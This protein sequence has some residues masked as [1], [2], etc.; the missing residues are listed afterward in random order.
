[1]KKITLS[2]IATGI[3]LAS[4]I[5][6][7]NGYS[8]FIIGAENFQYSE[9][10]IYTF[11]NAYIVGDKTYLPGQSVAVK[12][13]INVTSPVYMSGG[14]VRFSPKWDLS[15]DFI[16]TLKPNQTTEKW[17]DRGEGNTIITNYATIMSNSMRFLLHYKLTNQHRIAFGFNYILNNFKRYNNPDVQTTELVEETSASAM[18]D[19][20]YWFESNTAGKGFRLKYSIVG[21][22]P[23]Y[24]NVKNTKAPDL[25]FTKAK[26]Y[27]VDTSFYIGYSF[28]KGLELGLYAG[29]SYMYRDGDTKTYK[30][31]LVIWPT[32]ITRVARGGLQIT[33]NFK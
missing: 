12:S 23:V 19:L 24:Q 31:Q 14:I 22:Y 5:N 7:F 18:I 6:S 3:L 25:T 26:G 4:N 17:I 21:G 29:Y 11:K 1:M 20:G 13:K 8:Y 9:K 16:S 2:L 27:N 28:Y 32:N 33:W 10:F 15:M 30:D